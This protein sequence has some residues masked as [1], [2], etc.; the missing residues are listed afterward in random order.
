MSWRKHAEGQH[1]SFPDY[2][3]CNH[4]YFCELLALN[5]FTDLHRRWAGL[6]QWS[7]SIPPENVRKPLVECT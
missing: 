2:T 7:L 3:G 5:Q 6:T 1:F 4:C